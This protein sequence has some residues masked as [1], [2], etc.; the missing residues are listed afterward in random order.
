MDKRSL[1]LGALLL[2]ASG[3]TG[4]RSESQSAATS[5]TPLVRKVVPKTRTNM[6]HCNWY[7]L[8]WIAAGTPKTLDDMVQQM[9]AGTDG[10]IDISVEASTTNFGVVSW[11]CWRVAGTPFSWGAAFSGVPAMPEDEQKEAEPVAAEPEPAA[12]A[13]PLAVILPPPPPK[14]I[15][16]TER[17]LKLIGAKRPESEDDFRRLC[18][19][20]WT[21][22]EQ[23]KLSESQMVQKARIGSSRVAPGSSLMSVLNAGVAAGAGN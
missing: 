16:L 2:L 15:P 19:E 18:S 21:L 10:M 6:A 13:A 23:N 9:T 3:L 17:L 5:N 7:A 12:P 22:K 4:F 8:G 1:R 11:H 14:A 20:V